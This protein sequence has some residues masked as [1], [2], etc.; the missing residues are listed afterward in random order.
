MIKHTC[1]NCQKEFQHS[2][3]FARVAGPLAGYLLGAKNPKIAIAL[4][5]AGYAIGHW[6]DE[7]IAEN[8]DPICPTCG[9]VLHLAV[10]EI[11]T[12]LLRSP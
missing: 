3:L 2:V 6:V 8:V 5:T 12:D 11:E 4:A 10:R 9:F 1:P 7:Y